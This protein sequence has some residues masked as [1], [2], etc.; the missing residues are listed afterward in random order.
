MTMNLINV[1]DEL[2]KG[3]KPYKTR[4]LTSIDTIVIHHSATKDGSPKAFAKYHVEH[5]KWPGIAYHAVIGKKGEL[6]QTNYPQTISYHAVGYNSRSIG[7]CLVGDL[8]L[9]KPTPQQWEALRWLIDYYKG[10]LSEM[11]FLVGHRETGA[12]KSCPGLNFNMELLREEAKM[13]R[14]ATVGVQ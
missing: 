5:N 14:V 8:D 1:T 11:K 13:E 4:A 10:R 2:L 3:F 12:K 9:D 7:I 6:W